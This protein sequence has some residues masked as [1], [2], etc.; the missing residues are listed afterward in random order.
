MRHKETRILLIEQCRKLKVPVITIKID[1]RD[2][3]R[4]SK[5]SIETAARNL[6]IQNL[7]EIAKGQNCSCIAAAHHKND[8]AETIIDRLIRGTGLRGL[9]GIWPAKEFNDG[10]SFIRPLLCATRDEI[11]QYLN[12]GNLKWCTDRTNTD[13]AYRRNFIRHRLLPDFAERFSESILLNSLQ[14]VESVSRI[15]S[16]DLQNRRHDLARCS[17]C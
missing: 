12:D 2:Y 17:H 10:I 6:R 8:N 1:V 3:A 11:I 13:F 9:C 14:S 4:K 7:V 16:D 5:L 15:L